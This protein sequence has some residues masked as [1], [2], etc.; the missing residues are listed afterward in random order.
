MKKILLF[1]GVVISAIHMNAQD[2][3]ALVAAEKAFAETCLSK[4]IRDGFLAYVDS[5]AIEFGEEGPVNAKKIWSSLPSFEGVFTWSPTIAEISLSG[6]WG[7]TSG[8][9]EHRAK[10]MAD[11]PNAYG[12]YTTVWQMTPAG[13]WK[14]VI[15]IGN[16]HPQASLDQ[17]SKIISGESKS[18][19]QGTESSILDTERD[20]ILS[21]KKNIREAYVNFG[22][23]NYFLNLTGYTLVNNKDSAVLLIMNKA[24]ELNYNPS[25][26]IIS[27]PHDMAAIYGTLSKGTMHGSYVRIWRYEKNGWKIALEVIRIGK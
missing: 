19:L 13:Q 16:P 12:Q 1:G 21:Y 20:F 10:S 11:T 3:R 14:Y 8:N 25:G 17:A 23:K 27:G 22:S 9:F 15:D 2:A 6:D 24:P 26:V 18:D 4:G 5:N 7:Y